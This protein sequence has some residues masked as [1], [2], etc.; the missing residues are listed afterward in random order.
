MKKAVLSKQ[1]VR[2]IAGFWKSRLIDIALQPG[3][4]PSTDRVRETV[5]NWLNPYLQDAV[6]YDLF[7][8]TGILGLES[9]SRGAKELFL[10]EKNQIAYQVIKDNIEK[11][12]PFPPQSQIHCIHSNALHWLKNLDQIA[13]KLI[14]LDPPFDEPQLLLEALQVISQRLKNHNHPI[15]YVESSAKLD[16]EAILEALP[17]YEVKKQ[18]VAGVVKASLLMSQTNVSSLEE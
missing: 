3:L 15:I 16:N 10:I 5:F 7:A 6:I 13:A 4:R 12:K 17:H 11:L 18:L 2:I 14:F 9:C 1:R 8:G